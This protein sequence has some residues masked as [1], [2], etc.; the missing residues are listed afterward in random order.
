MATPAS[1][2]NI[3]EKLLVW[4]LEPGALVLP[5]SLKGL[6]LRSDPDPYEAFDTGILPRVPA[7]VL[8]TRRIS[9]YVYLRVAGGGVSGWAWSGKF[10]VV[11]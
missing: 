11:A 4:E 6:E 9:S 2:K 3:P 7:L 5:R 8:E 1:P 10:E